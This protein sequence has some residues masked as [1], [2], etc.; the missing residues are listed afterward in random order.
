[1]PIPMR[2]PALGVLVVA[3]FFVP[4][5][6][7]A[8]FVTMG[9]A[10]NAR[11]SQRPLMSGTSV[12]CVLRDGSA[13]PIAHC[14]LFARRPEHE[15]LLEKAHVAMRK[16]RSTH[17][18]FANF[19][20]E[21]DILYVAGG[22]GRGFSFLDPAI[23][24]PPWAGDRWSPPG[25]GIEL[26]ITKASSVSYE[27]VMRN[28]RGERLH[29]I[30]GTCQKDPAGSKTLRVQTDFRFTLGGET[31]SEK[32]PSLIFGL[33]G[34]GT[35][36]NLFREID[37]DRAPPGPFVREDNRFLALVGRE[38]RMMFS[39]PR[40]GN[41]GRRLQEFAV[42]GPMASGS[43]ACDSVPGAQLARMFGLGRWPPGAELDPLDE[44]VGV[45]IA[46]L[47]CSSSSSTTD[48]QDGHG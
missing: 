46:S 37:R 16:Y 17:P 9:S 18:H 32:G 41:E 6:V 24:P 28:A 42:S 31:G 13:L 19:W 15:T 14:T 7:K 34:D 48:S 36:E 2:I 22:P 39:M 21:L 20:S 23:H 4:N 12:R 30:T 25:T 5:G 27:I 26:V 11:L 47:D 40:P 44:E 33:S 3:A 8:S 1:M 10:W 45:L 29:R 35:T 43:S 38:R